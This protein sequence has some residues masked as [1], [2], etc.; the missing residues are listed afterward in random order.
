[1][2]R[3]LNTFALVVLAALTAGAWLGRPIDSL[4]R[5]VVCGE[6]D[7]L[8]AELDRRLA[9]DVAPIL[10][11]FC[12]GC[13][14]GDEPEA[15]LALD[16]LTG[17]EP[18]LAGGFDLRLIREMIS[19]GEMPPARKP[20]PTDHQRLILTQWIDAALEYIPPTAAVDPGWFTIHR[21]NRNEYRNTLRGLLGI[22]PADADLAA[23]LP[24]DDTGY[25]FDNIADVL[26]VSPL[27]VEQYLAAA[28]RAIDLALGPVVEFGDHPRSLRPIEGRNG[29]PLPRGGFML[30]SNGPASARF[31]A[32]LAGEY[33]ARVRLWE[34][35]AGDEHARASIRLGRRSLE[36]FEIS[37]TRGSPQDV[38]V[39]FR[40]EPGEHEIAA[41][42][43]NDYYVPNVAD[44]NLAVESISVAG[45]LDPATT[46]RP[47]AWSAVFAPAETEPTDEG[48]ARAIL[49]AFATQAYRRPATDDDAARLL[50]VY[51]AERDEGRGFE[52][53]VRAA[54]SAALVSPNFLFRSVAQQDA[55]DPRA[56][57]TLDGFELAS[58]LSYFL[59]SSM[60]DKALF[61]AAADGTILSDEGL[62]SHTRRMLA[63][64]RASAFVDNFSGQWLQLR[65]LDSLA[66]DQARFPEFD[67]A[68]RAD[69]LR[70]ATL[71]FRDVLLSGRSVLDLIHSR[72]T[73]LNER[74]ARHYGIDLVSGPEFRRVTL[75]DRSP[76][77]GVL[78]MAAVL[79][80]TSNPARTSPVK[81]GLFVLD[82]FL[83]A[84]PPPPPADIPPLE[85]AAG[86]PPDATVREQLA[87]HTAVASCAACH[88]RLDP[89]GLAFEN[90]DAIGRWRETEAGRPIDA[91]GILPGGIPLDGP[92]DLKRILLERDDQFIEA[93]SGKIL[94]YAVGRG[95]EPFDRPAVR[96]IAQRTRDHHDT[97]SALIES[98]VLSETFRTCR[99]RSPT[100]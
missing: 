1:M 94:V 19:T 97:L 30:Y 99:G 56:R 60:P 75:P 74:L 77:G 28:E 23:R 20:Q 5:P 35:H 93:L 89:I 9:H 31:T 88:N 81:R 71:F 50:R 83:A 13:H 22:D 76:R 10:A 49:H 4:D 52:P 100:P 27:A 51:R 72:D 38:E 34:T 18:A 79:T 33:I 78:T 16:Q 67:E 66:I 14:A 54:L 48:R 41:H 46:T 80:L 68:L 32:P 15:D 95:L 98:V 57:H 12:L 6:P 17:I 11:S 39:R 70:E 58:R 82:Q 29:Q 65:A 42:F 59:W 43:I 25:G 69:M 85:Q 73:F 21:L 90:F 45:P 96:R 91:S 84:P 2:R 44:R 63:D 40:S 64:P 61:L 92:H 7:P 37:G 24:Q 26:S 36:E 47:T 53:A 87:A 86:L 8:A 55:A 3:L 62:A